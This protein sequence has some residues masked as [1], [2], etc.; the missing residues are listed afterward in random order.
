MQTSYAES[1]FSGY[2]GHKY[3]VGL[4]SC[5]SAIFLG[6]RACGVTTGDV[7]LSNALT[8]NAVPSAIE[9]CGAKG[10]P[11]AAASACADMVLLVL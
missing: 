1:E 7:V 5:G 6:L 8:F 4:N 11:P 2:T 9:H 3:C 10:V